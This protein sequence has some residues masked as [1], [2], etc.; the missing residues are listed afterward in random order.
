MKAQ[1]KEFYDKPAKVPVIPP[2]FDV[3]FEVKYNPNDTKKINSYLTIN[4][5]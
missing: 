4:T 2:T 1:I 3:T 5:S